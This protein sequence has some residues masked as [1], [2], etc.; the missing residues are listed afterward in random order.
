MKIILKNIYNL[1]NVHLDTFV[2][3]IGFF[4]IYWKEL[5]NMTVQINKKDGELYTQPDKAETI[6]SKIDSISLLMKKKV[7][8]I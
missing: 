6:I 4:W 8:I 1:K 7:Y 5:K 3:L 2:V